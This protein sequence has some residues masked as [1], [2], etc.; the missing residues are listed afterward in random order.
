MRA[1]GVE[2]ANTKSSLVDVVTAA[3]REAEQL[4]AEALRAARPQYGL[5]GEE[6]LSAPSI[7]GITWV[8]DPIDGTVNYL[9]DLPSYA[10]SIAATVDVGAPGTM[11]EGRREVDGAVYVPALDELFT[12]HEI[13]ARHR[14]R[15]QKVEH[16]R[17]VVRGSR[18]QESLGGIH[19]PAS[20]SEA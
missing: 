13:A 18:A 14:V 2:I 12:A 15:R 1:Q 17:C 10:V 7:S 3:D 11:A 6:G 19:R 5:L 9:Y 8:V 4:V 20:G 16:A